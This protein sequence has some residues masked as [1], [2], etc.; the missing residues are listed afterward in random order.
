[1]CFLTPVGAAERDAGVARARMFMQELRQNVSDGRRTNAFG[2]YHDRFDQDA[3]GRWW[4]AARR[5]NSFSR[6][7]VEGPEHEQVVFP[8]PAITLADL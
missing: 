8:L 2:V 4:I 7:Q 3:D 5:Y 6:T 1:L